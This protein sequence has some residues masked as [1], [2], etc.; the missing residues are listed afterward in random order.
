MSRYSSSTLLGSAKRFFLENEARKARRRAKRKSAAPIGEP[1]S[2]HTF[3]TFSGGLSMESASTAGGP[4]STMPRTRPLAPLSSAASSATAHKFDWPTM[5]Q[6][7]P[8][9][10][11]T[12]DSVCSAHSV[13]VRGG[14]LQPPN[15]RFILGFG[16]E[17]PTPTTSITC[18][19]GP[20]ASVDH[21]STKGLQNVR[22][23]PTPI[24]GSSTS[25]G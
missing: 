8:T 22:S 19:A 12:Y 24:G 5:M 1:T 9:C 21:A 6:G 15:G 18:S 11:R 2:L 4:T 14:S 20:G 25:G 23:M 13:G 16:D 17:S 10:S 7:S 3:W